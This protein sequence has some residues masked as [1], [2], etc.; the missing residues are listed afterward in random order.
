MAIKLNKRKLKEIAIARGYITSESAPRPLIYDI[1]RHWR[2]L[3]DAT[4]FQSLNPGPW[5]EQEE[6]LSE[7]IIAALTYLQCINCSN[8]ERLLEDTIERHARQ[9]E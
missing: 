8:I 5:N 2:N 9:N 6:A 4:K 3:L 7:I 1:S